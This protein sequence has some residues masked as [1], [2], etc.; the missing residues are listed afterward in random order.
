M[1]YTVS[2]LDNGNEWTNVSTYDASVLSRIANLLSTRQLSCP[3]YRGFGLPM[4]F[5]DKPMNVAVPI[6]VV[7]ITEGLMEWVPEATLSNLTF[8]YDLNNP[9]KTVPIVEVEINEAQ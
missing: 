7:E 8:T 3:M 6:A 2:A 1:K 5:V 4:R 9:G